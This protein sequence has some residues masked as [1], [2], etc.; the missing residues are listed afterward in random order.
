MQTEAAYQRCGEND[1]SLSALKVIRCLCQ[2]TEMKLLN[3]YHVGFDCYLDH[4]PVLN[5]HRVSRCNAL[6]LQ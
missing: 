2:K 3:R 4:T 5:M 6:F 1:K